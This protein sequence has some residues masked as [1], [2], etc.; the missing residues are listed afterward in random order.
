M[1]QHVQAQRFLLAHGQCDFGADALQVFQRADVAALEGRTGLADGRGLR[2]RA[3]GGGRQQRQLQRFALA[4]DA[5]CERA[6]AA[7]HVGGDASQALL[8]ARVDHAARLPARG[9]HGVGRGQLRGD[10]GITLVERACQHL[11]LIELLGGEGQPRLQFGI[12]AHLMRQ[13][14]RHMQQRAGGRQPQAVA[15]RRLHGAQRV[16]HAAQIG[17]PDIAAVDDAG[18]QHG[19]RRQRGLPCGQ[20]ARCAHQV[21]MEAVDRQRGSARGVVGGGVEVRRQQQLR[22]RV[23]QAV[24]GAVEG[25]EPCRFQVQAQRG[26][27]DLH[28][29]DAARLELAEDAAVGL[30][31]LRQQREAVEA[32]HVALGQPQVG[33]RANQHRARAQ[34]LRQRFV[35]FL[36]E[37]CRAAV[38]GGVGI[39]LG[40]QVVVVGVEPLGHFHCRL[41][42]VAARQLEILRQRQLRRV[43]AEAARQGAQQ[44]GQAEHLVVVGEVAGSHGVQA[45][46]GLQLP[47]A[48]AQLRGH[49]AQRGFAAFTAPEGLLREFQFAAFA[50]AGK[51]EDMGACHGELAPEDDWRTVSVSP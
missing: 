7:G 10:G 1:D 9:L 44:R 36:E 25:V 26:F 21:D 32:G 48:A 41:F 11:Q 12:E 30:H 4:L 51:A 39:Q 22:A 40:D 19:M 49:I 5:L 35:G 38:E 47:V 20:L 16:E 14:H 46:P 24:V 31:Q 28:P 50:D 18:G 15:E 42:A 17:A 13:R 2:E 6:G 27:V 3:D 8:H 37:P 34:A 33:D 43:E 45:V 23:A 29:F